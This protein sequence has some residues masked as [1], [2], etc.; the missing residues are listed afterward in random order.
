MKTVD[1][2]IIVFNIP[3]FHR[4]PYKWSVAFIFVYVKLQLFDIFLFQISFHSHNNMMV[5]IIVVTD[6]QYS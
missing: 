6:L 2:I 5:E 1:Y 4:A 3:I